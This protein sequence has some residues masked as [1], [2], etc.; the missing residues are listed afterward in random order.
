MKYGTSLWRVKNQSNYQYFFRFPR[1]SKV[2]VFIRSSGHNERN[3]LKSL[4]ITC[5]F[6][7]MRGIAAACSHLE[8]IGGAAPSSSAPF[9]LGFVHH[10]AALF[11]ADPIQHAVGL[12]GG[13]E[14]RQLTMKLLSCASVGCERAQQ[15]PNSQAF[16][17]I[18]LS[19]KL[20]EISR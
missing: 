10:R 7:T 13:R 3:L 6:K 12:Q 16:R 1:Y 11:E 20:A 4:D 14:R 5:R 19:K 15:P 17:T 18:M 2:L 9:H 8:H